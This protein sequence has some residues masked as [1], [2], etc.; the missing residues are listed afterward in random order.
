MLGFKPELVAMVIVNERNAAK[1]L[2]DPGGGFIRVLAVIG[3]G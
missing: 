3:G 1:R 2:C